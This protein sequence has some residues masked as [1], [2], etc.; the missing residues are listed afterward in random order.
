MRLKISVSLRHDGKKNI[1]NI[2]NKVTTRQQAKIANINNNDKNIINKTERKNISNT[3]N[4]LQKKQQKKK[5]LIKNLMI[6]LI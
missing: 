2:D 4:T 6:N 5:L 1:T 3:N